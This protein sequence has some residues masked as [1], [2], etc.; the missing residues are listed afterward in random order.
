MSTEHVVTRSVRDSAAFL[1][2]TAGPDV[3]APYFATPPATPF[4]DEVGREPGKLRIA[5]S[6]FTP[7]GERVSKD[8]EDALDVALRLLAAAGHHLEEIR[9]DFVPEALGPAFR[10]I[11]AGNIRMAID[12]YATASARKPV[13]DQFERV[14]WMFYEAGAQAS[15]ADYARAVTVL[16][17]T[18]RQVASFFQRYDLL[19][20][21][22]LPKAPER[23]G[24]FD[25]DAP[26]TE[27]YGNAIALFTSFTAPFNASGNPAVSVPLHWNAQ[28]LPIGIQ[29]AGRYGDEA[30]LLRVSAQ[31]ERAQPWFDRRA[32]VHSDS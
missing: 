27:A 8:A 22:T 13:A 15:A 7:A 5:F 10:T 26:A 19:L 11:I 29:L 32:P 17:R 21:P 1:D 9:I 14:T 28:G 24:V 6:R 25:M 20:T 4:L 16:H 3:G 30:T 23:I 12:N 18:G 31:L 2:V